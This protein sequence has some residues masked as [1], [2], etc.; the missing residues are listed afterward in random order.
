M[1]V[2]LLLTIWLSCLNAMAQPDKPVFAKGDM[3][4]QFLSRV[5][6]DEAGKTKPGVSDSYKLTLNYSDSVL[7]AGEIKYLPTIISSVLGREVQQARIDYSL[8][9]SVINPANTKQSKVIGRLTGAVPID[10]YGVYQF[11]QGTM[12]IGVD[13]SGRAPAF[14]SK[15]TGSAAGKPPVSD[16][17]FARAKKQAV[18]I[19][20]E[21]RGA[22]KQIVVS[23]YDKLTFQNHGIASG[24]VQTYGEAQLNGEMLY[25]YERKAWYF[26]NVLMSYQENGKTH[27]DKISGNIKWVESPQRKSNGEGEYQFDIRLNEPESKSNDAAVFAG[28]ADESSFF[29]TDPSLSCLTGSMKYKD[30]QSGDNVT[31]S[32]IKIDLVGSKITR[33]QGAM[34]IKIIFGTAI[35]PFNNE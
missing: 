32:D 13:A 25:D 8:D 11:E 5:Q 21:V 26:N 22:T 29:E 6:L 20:R 33:S 7:F 9:L 18:S 30:Q 27:S 16:S 34:L 17:L 15:F 4:I 28:K 19:T 10:S 14:V 35:V 31:K 24:P 23:D 1:L 3:T 2:T 12:R